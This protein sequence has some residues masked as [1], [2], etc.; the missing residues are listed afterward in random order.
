MPI[1]PFKLF[2]NIEKGVKQT[3]LDAKSEPA[4][5]SIGPSGRSSQPGGLSQLGYACFWPN[6][7]GLKEVDD[8]DNAIMN[9]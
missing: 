5:A 7:G 8:N 2:Y 3:R 4:A 1:E 9:E 6:G